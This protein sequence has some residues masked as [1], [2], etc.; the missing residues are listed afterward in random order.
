MKHL[1]LQFVA[2]SCGLGFGLFMIL[3]AAWQAQAIDLTGVVT[4]R[5]LSPMVDL[6]VGV[7]LLAFGWQGI[8]LELAKPK[9]S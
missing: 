2:A 8:R 7:I 6:I 4:V 5:A 9:R 3:L 1:H